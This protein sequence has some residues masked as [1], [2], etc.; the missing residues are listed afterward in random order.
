MSANMFDASSAMNVMVSSS[1][2][3]TIVMPTPA[4]KSI[5]SSS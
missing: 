5:T 4:I 2:S 3:A 1:A